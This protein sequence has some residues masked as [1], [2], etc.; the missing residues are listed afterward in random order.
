MLGGDYGQKL[1]EAHQVYILLRDIENPIDKEKY[2]IFYMFFI[3]NDM[4]VF[5]LP[6]LV[7][8]SGISIPNLK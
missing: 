4:K 8:L 5:N 7:G 1:A 6:G 3:H 2:E